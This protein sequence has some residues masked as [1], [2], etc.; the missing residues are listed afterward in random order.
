MTNLIWDLHSQEMQSA[1]KTRVDKTLSTAE[2]AGHNVFDI[3]KTF[4]KAMSY[5]SNVSE[6]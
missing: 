4:K 1:I 5:S 2:S 6:M 3:F